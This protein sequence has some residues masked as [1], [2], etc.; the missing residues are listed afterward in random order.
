M[1][2]PRSMGYIFPKRIQAAIAGETTPFGSKFYQGG[3]DKEGKEKQQA[4]ND[5]DKLERAEKQKALQE[6]RSPWICST[7]TKIMRNKLDQKYYNKTGMCM[8][9]A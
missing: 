8:D 5:A 4:E 1:A 9:C 3:V 7:C 2:K 6:A